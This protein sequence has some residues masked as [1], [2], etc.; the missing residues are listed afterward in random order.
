MQGFTRFALQLAPSFL[1]ICL[2][3]IGGR[4][5][6]QEVEAPGK[7]HDPGSVFAPTGY[8]ELIVPLQRRIGLRLYGFYVGEVKVPV[9]QLD[10][11]VQITKFLTI[12]PSYLYV[13]VPA[14]GLNTAVSRQPAQFTRNYEEHQFRIDGT[15]KFPIR[16]FE[17]SDR[18]MYVRRFR[19]TDEINRYRNRIMVAHPLTVKGHIWK[20]YA[21]YEAFYDWPNVGWMRHRVWAG[22]TVALE[23]HVSFQPSYI[24]DSSRNLKDIDYLMVALFSAPNEDLIT[25][26]LERRLPCRKCCNGEP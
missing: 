9:A 22:V 7:T 18:N 17:I 13:N 15:L 16:K 26:Y 3:S 4:C 21:S 12:T 25:N 1:V 10:V 23:K 6:A 20:P 14:S 19:P 8:L 2:V 24:H 5:V 11:P